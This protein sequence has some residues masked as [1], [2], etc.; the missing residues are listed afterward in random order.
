MHPKYFW[1]IE[2]TWKLLCVYYKKKVNIPSTYLVRITY[3]CDILDLQFNMKLLY[4][5]IK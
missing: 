3:K 2:R 4:H 1:K 5:D